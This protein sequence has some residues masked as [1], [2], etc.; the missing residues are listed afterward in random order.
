MD[1][2]EK[3]KEYLQ[4]KKENKLTVSNIS[5]NVIEGFFEQIKDI[6]CITDYNGKIEYINNGEVYN[7]YKMLKEVLLYDQNNEEI[8]AKII[9]KTMDEGRFIGNV[10][11]NKDGEKVDV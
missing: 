10:Q 7:K 1:I 3:F 4:R 11:L 5:I 9:F 2:I 8:Y 6:I